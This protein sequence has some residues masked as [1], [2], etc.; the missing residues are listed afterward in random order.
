MWF[1]IGSRAIQEITQ[2]FYRDLSK[3]DL[4]LYCSQDDFNQL[5]TQC[6]T[7]EKCFPLKKNKYR[8]KIKNYPVIELKIYNEQ[9]VYDWLSKKEQKELL[10]ESIYQLDKFSVNIPNLNCLKLIKQSHLYWPIHWLKNI[11]D[12]TWLKEKTKNSIITEKE[13]KFFIMIKNEMKELHG[14]I[15]TGKLT[16]LTSLSEENITQE[17]LNEKYEKKIVYFI[18]EKLSLRNKIKIIQSWN[19]FKYLLKN[20]A[21]VRIKNKY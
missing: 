11:E 14:K 1:L 16:D 21:T 7:L 20:E 17:L 2:D 19:D 3:S 18:H 15:P 4:D 5:I 6:K 10:S 8:I 9:S 12:F 13:K